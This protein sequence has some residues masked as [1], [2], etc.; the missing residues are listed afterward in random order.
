MKGTGFI[1]YGERKPGMKKEQLRIEK[2]IDGISKIEV[3]IVG[4]I[5]EKKLIQ[6]WDGF[7]ELSLTKD[8]EEVP[9]WMVT[10]EW[11]K[12]PKEWAHQGR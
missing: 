11:G 1:R 6:T 10:G 3:T 12:I 5:E 2:Y 7:K 8:H 4:E 9:Y